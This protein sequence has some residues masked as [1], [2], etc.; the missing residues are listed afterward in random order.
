[1]HVHIK[2]LSGKIFLSIL[3]TYKYFNNENNAN[4]STEKERT[5]HI[6]THSN[7]YCHGVP[8]SDPDSKIKD[9]VHSFHPH[10]V[11]Q[12]AVEIV[13]QKGQLFADL[14]GIVYTLHLALWIEDSS[15]DEGA[16]TSNS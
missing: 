9:G 10:F 15:L 8:D 4:Y 6:T 12:S 16:S 13:L 11:E 14:N 3:G 2:I 1:M 7:S 5:F